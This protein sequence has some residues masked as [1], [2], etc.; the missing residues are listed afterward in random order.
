MRKRVILITNAFP[1]GAHEANFVKPELPYLLQNFDLTIVTK[2]STDALVAELGD[3]IDVYR[4]STEMIGLK[5]LIRNIRWILSKDFIEE[6]LHNAKRPDKTIRLLKF[7]IRAS[8]FARFADSVRKQYDQPVIFYCF[9]NDYTAYGTAKLCEITGDKCVSRI[10]GGDLY[11]LS[12]NHY[13]QPLKKALARRFDRIIFISHA[14]KRYY[15]E[16]YAPESEQNLVCF[17]MGI[18]NQSGIRNQPSTDGVLRLVSVSNIIPGKRVE[19]IAAA[20]S[21]I[22]DLRIEWTHIGNGETEQYVKERTN[23]YLSGKTN[24]S[25]RFLGRL[26][27]AKVREYYETECLDA[28]LNVS[29]S[30]GLPVSMME[31]A[32]YGV[33]LIGTNVGGVSE[34]IQTDNGIL[35]EKDFSDEE[36]ADVLKRFCTMD[37]ETK[38]R[39]RDS[40]Y[41]VWETTFDAKKNYQGLVKEMEAL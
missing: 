33:P 35:I 37:T 36:L 8:H 17:Y 5:D 10:H 6:L 39:M 31:A 21:M 1:Y 32:S 41:R 40:S 3:N 29:I 11:K 24:I 7:A 26:S 20:L 4:Y 30:E 23:A 18:D 27:N 16:N 25:Y 34:I 15:I 28:L 13:Y 2:N 12:E 19:R 14:G 38:M 9:W 22:S